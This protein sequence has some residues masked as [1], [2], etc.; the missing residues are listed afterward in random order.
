MFSATCSGNGLLV[1]VTGEPG[2]GKTTLVEDF[3]SELADHDPCIGRGRCSERLAGT[4]AYLPILEALENMLQGPSGPQ[5]ARLMK[6]LAPTWFVQVGSHSENSWERLLAEA[7][8]AS[9]DRMKREIAA[10]FQE[11][12]RIRPV[13][14]FL[15]DLH[16]A[17]ASTIDVLAYLADRCRLLRLLIVATYRPSYLLL[18]GH[19]FVQV[20]LELQARG[21]CRELPLDFLTRQDIE[22][23]LALAFSRHRFP[24]EFATLIHGRTEGNPLFMVDL[25]SY[26]RDR[27][28]LV[29]DA[30]GS[31]LGRRVSD[32]SG[33]L[34]ESVRSMIQRKIDWLAEEDRRLLGGASVQG[35][36]FDSAVIASALGMDAAQIEERL[37][38][39]ERVHGFVRQL[40]ET[41]LP[42]G[43]F[44]LRYQFVHKPGEAL[45]EAR[46]GRG[47]ARSARRNLRLVYRGL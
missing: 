4:E 26:L 32:I 41:A 39:L 47:G 31:S 8:G 7:K 23:Y 46:E 1:C 25:L 37:E 17:D 35:Y 9:Q 43:T 10:F 33:E 45:H 24:A 27:G 21:A 6:T 28:V 5:W 29:E 18:T 38:L 15:D 13:L 40:R 34:P 30:S 14:L 3:L 36:E 12:A 42:D 16:W 20:K 44:F 22:N 19:P 11:V 2:I